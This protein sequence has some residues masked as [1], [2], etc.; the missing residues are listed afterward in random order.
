ML[1]ID[2]LEIIFKKSKKKLF[3]FHQYAKMIAVEIRDKRA[4]E[5]SVIEPVQNRAGSGCGLASRIKRRG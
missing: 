1:E 3:E 2:M 4:V 5:T